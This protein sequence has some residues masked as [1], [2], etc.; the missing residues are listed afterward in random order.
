MTLNGEPIPQLLMTIIQYVTS[1]KDHTIKKLLLL[2]WES[3]EKLD[4]KG[5]LLPEMIL[6]CNT[7]LNDLNHPN[8]YIRG[9]TLRFLSKM[10]EE[11][12]L[13]PL[14]PSILKN[15]E[16]RHTYPRRNA[17]LTLF[18]VYKNF[19]SLIPDVPEIV[20]EYLS[21]ET[22]QTSRRNAFLMLFHCKQEKA[23]EFLNLNLAKL[24]TFGDT[25]QL[26]AVDVIKRVCRASPS[27]RY[28]Y[29]KGIFT[30]LQS[31]SAAVQYESAGVL[32][33]LSSAPTAVKAAASTYINLLIK[34][35]SNNV[36]MIVLDR[37]ME[38]KAKHQKVLQDLLMDILRA[39][40]R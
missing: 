39:L 32:V 23:V 17:V 10:R 6:V 28:K 16:H 14:L 31:N 37:L 29:L 30:L 4:D 35:S 21:K 1:E 34:E 9:S 8:E 19:P 38:I 25:M 20:F 15:L 40:N 13:E 2:Y 26:V 24:D 11:E 22:D 33:S 18:S 7:L 12:L 27:E 5:K 3:V 36:K